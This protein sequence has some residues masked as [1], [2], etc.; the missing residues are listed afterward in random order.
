MLVTG[1]PQAWQAPTASGIGAGIDS[2]Y[3]YALKMYVMS[4]EAQYFDVFEEAYKNVM[5][6]SLGYEGYWVSITLVLLFSATHVIQPSVPHC[7][8]AQWGSRYNV[9][10]FPFSLLGGTAGEP[11]SQR[12]SR[13]RR[14]SLCS[15]FSRRCKKRYQVSFNM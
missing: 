2:F 14:L 15:G 8:H 4:G 7:E 12:Q 10:R 3:E 11:F 6:H 9:H 5:N 13:N 1:P